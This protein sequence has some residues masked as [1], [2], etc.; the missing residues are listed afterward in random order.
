MKDGLPYGCGQCL[1]CR[2]NKRR[3][4]TTR[5]MLEA[6]CH[7][8]SSFI[9]LTYA[10]EHEQGLEFHNGLPSLNP[11]HLK[12]FMKRIRRKV[13]P[14]KLRFYGVGEYGTQTQ[15]PHY[16]I[17]LFGFP[18]CIYGTPRIGRKR[19]SQEKNGDKYWEINQC[20]CDSCQTIQS[21]WDYG[22]TLNG[23]LTKESS[24]YVCGYVTKKMT[25]PKNELVQ[26]YLKGRY[27]E[28]ARMSNRPGIGANSL[29]SI[30]EFLETEHGCD[31]LQLL[32]D[33]PNT[34]RLNG[35]VRPLGT[36]LKRKLREKM[37]WK[38]TS[39]PKELLQ[40]MQEEAYAEAWED[41]NSKEFEHLRTKTGYSQKDILLEKNKQKVKNLEKR[42]NL[43]NKGAKL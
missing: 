13:E 10:P 37:A 43:F 42:F 1:P 40:R 22:F 31:F 20:P 15:R 23:T 30:V 21:K 14:H 26:D 19:V 24:S 3:L 33:V 34:I 5:M 29:D 28:F 6:E 2:I 25:N 12:N 18:P 41:F 8:E 27:P 9:T 7:R 17:A 11:D 38:E 4:W 32:G 35:Q 39:T 36:Y 16:H